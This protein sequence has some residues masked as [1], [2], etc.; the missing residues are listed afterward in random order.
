MQAPAKLYIN[1]GGYFEDRTEAAGL[2]LQ[3]LRE[4]TNAA[5]FIDHDADGDLDL[6]IGDRDAGIHLFVQEDGRFRAHPASPFAGPGPWESLAAADYDGDGRVDVFVCAYGLIDVDHQPGSYVDADDGAANVLLRN[7]GEAGF[8]D[9]T[10]AVGLAPHARRWSYGAAWADYDRDGDLDL[11]VADD[12]GPNVLLRNDGG[13][14]V[15]TAAASGAEDRGNGMSVTWFDADGDG[16]LDLY[17][18]NMQSFAGNRIARSADF[19]GTPAQVAL[20]AR[21]AQGNT[22]LRGRGDGTFEDIT[23]SAGVK[24]AYWAW[25]AVPFDHDSDGDTDL[26]CVTGMFTG[27][28]S[29]DT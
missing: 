21:F 9:V 3:V 24:S 7:V 18:S 19:P 29:A 6:V 14:F 23:R 10:T 20:Y 13:R 28:S 15:D 26:L 27:P 8:E 16:I 4:G 2:A 17:V 5:L 1:D 11:Y 22:L 12:Y 25:G